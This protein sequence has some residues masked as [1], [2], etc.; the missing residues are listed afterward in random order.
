MYWPSDGTIFAII[1]NP[2]VCSTTMHRTTL[3]PAIEST[4]DRMGTFMNSTVCSIWDCPMRLCGKSPSM[5]MVSMPPIH[6][7]PLTDHM[8]VQG[9]NR[10]PAMSCMMQTA[11]SS[12]WIFQ[13]FCPGPRRIPVPGITTG[14]W[15]I[16]TIRDF[17]PNLPCRASSI[18]GLSDLMEEP[19]NCIK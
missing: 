16:I 8:L 7:L 6:F 19:A 3:I 2:E 5:V 4:I 12:V 9:A 1:V 13:M 14:L 17:L 10:Y 18:P 15:I 11:L